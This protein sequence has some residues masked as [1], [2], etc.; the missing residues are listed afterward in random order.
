MQ[1]KPIEKTKPGG[2]I[3]SNFETLREYMKGTAL[4]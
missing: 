2:F 1:R 4:I 3:W